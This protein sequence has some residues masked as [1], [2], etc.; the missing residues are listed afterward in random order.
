VIETLQIGTPVRRFRVAN[1]FVTV[2]V[3]CPRSASGACEGVLSLH[4]RVGRRLTRLGGGEFLTEPGTRDPVLVA[5][6]R[7]ARSLVRTKKRLHAIL[8][9][10]AKDDAGKTARLSRSVQLL[11]G[12]RR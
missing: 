1:G 8:L 6:T 5:L 10:R 3:V 9:V 11:S 2:P 12:R 4:Y 7:R